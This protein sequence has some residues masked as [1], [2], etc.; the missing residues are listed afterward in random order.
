[1][2]ERFKPFNNQAINNKF[3]DNIKL[4]FR[5]ILDLQINTVRKTFIIFKNTLYN[6]IQY[7]G[8]GVILDVGCG[9]SPYKSLLP[10]NLK[11]IG[12]DYNMAQENF[13]YKKPEDVILYDGKDFPFENNSFDYLYHTETLEHI[14]AP[15]YFLKECNRVLKDNGTMFFSVPFQARYYYI[16]FDYYRYTPASLE[17]LLEEAGFDNIKIIERGS[18]ITVA[19]YKIVSVFHRMLLDRGVKGLINKTLA[20]LFSPVYLIFLL[21]AHISLI[22]NLGS[23]DDCLG[24]SVISKKSKNYE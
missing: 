18:D 24:Y 13:D 10:K 17:M 2:I 20:I 9:N 3:I 23:K 6:N 5:L 11:Y 16:P 21:I 1:M 4:F 8:G 7:G 15:A 19:A 14:K 12:L 22:F